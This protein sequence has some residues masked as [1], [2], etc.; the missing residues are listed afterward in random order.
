VGAMGQRAEFRAYG[1]K[2]LKTSN[3]ISRRVVMSLRIGIDRYRHAP[4]LLHSDK[5][6]AS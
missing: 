2:W 5:S 6:K 3:S 4:S 1:E